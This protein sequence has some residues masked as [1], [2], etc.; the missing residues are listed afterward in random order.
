MDTDPCFEAF[1]DTPQARASRYAGFV[2]SAIP[3]GEWELIRSALQRGQLTG[4]ERFV[5]EAVAII[6]RRIEHRQRGRPLV[7]TGKIDPSPLRPT[8][9]RGRNG[10]VEVGSAAF[11]AAPVS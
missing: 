2:R 5:G 11:A 1:G 6:G 3:P 9:G 7:E 10:E 4:Y 8:L